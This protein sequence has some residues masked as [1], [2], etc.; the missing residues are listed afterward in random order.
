[1]AALAHPAVD[2]LFG[3]ILAL[4]KIGLDGIEIVHP[5]QSRA[6]RK[7]LIAIAKTHGLVPTGGSDF[8]R[9]VGGRKLGTFGVNQ[10]TVDRMRACASGYAK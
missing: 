3:D 8:H 7:R 9:P 2:S 1:M 5:A 10:A 6:D 4:K